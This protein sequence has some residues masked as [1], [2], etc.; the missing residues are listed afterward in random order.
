M[1]KT[2]KPGD[3]K[4]KAT[5]AA[6]PKAAPR[7]AQKAA[8]K[9]VPQKASPLA[10]MKDKFGEKSKLIEAVTTFISDDLWVGRMNKDRGG[11]KGIERVSNSK[12]LRLHTIFAAVKDKFGTREKLISAIL[13]TE[14]RAKDEG[15]KSRLSAYPVPR[16]WDH[17]KTVEKRAKV[18]AAKAENAKAAPKA[19]KP[20]KKA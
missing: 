10:L 6:A 4:K 16:L 13:E 1:A 15:Y 20:A 11:D 5:T 2:T 19:E 9:K 7:D 8:P 17:Y 3:A 14:K 18:A 12:L